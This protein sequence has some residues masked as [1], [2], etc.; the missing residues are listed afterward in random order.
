M[1][2]VV[3]LNGADGVGK[4]TQAQTIAETN[5]DL[6][7]CIS[8][9]GAY[10]PFSKITADDWWFDSS[11]PEEFCDV[12]YAS[13]KNRNLAIQNSNKPVVIVDKGL[14]NFEA[15][16]IA[17]LLTRGVSKEKVFELV[18]EYKRKYDIKSPEDVKI[19]LN[20][21]GNLQDKIEEMDRRGI[22]DGYSDESQKRYKHYQELQNI[23]LETQLE[24]GIYIPVNAS[25]SIEEVNNDIMGIV[26]TNLR[27]RIQPISNNRQYIGI[28]GL[29]ESG[30]ST[31]GRIF[32]DQSNIPNLK[33]KY[34]ARQIGTKYGVEPYSDIFKNDKR[35]LA[36]LMCDEIGIFLNDMYYWDVVSFESIHD[37]ELSKYMKEMQPFNYNVLYLD[38]DKN[39]R[40]GRNAKELDVNIN[41]SEKKVEMKD[42]DKISVGAD[43]VKEVADYVV[44]NNGR[45]EDLSKKLY[46]VAES[47]RRKVKMRH[48]AGGILVEDGKVLLVH[49][50]KEKDGIID[51]YY[52]VPGGGIE[53]GETLEDAT[54]RELKEE[55]G[56][57]VELTEPE[58]RYVLEGENGNQYFSLVEKVG[59][60]IGTGKGPE[61]TDPEYKNRGKYSAEMISIQDIVSGKINMVP[62]VIKEKFIADFAGK[63][64]NGMRDVDDKGDR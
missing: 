17:T 61:F 10:E 49:R 37:A 58:P 16:I 1:K 19:F 55:V 11:T 21:D 41:E 13:L 36:A 51:E 23:V 9:L 12:L 59:G 30:K 62:Q 7:E 5:P 40:I 39:L 45:L 2:L 35:I 32:L 48:R 56:I 24:N 18:K 25:K 33:F 38:T 63:K 26:S 42:E 53:E 6:V 64:R 27:H 57:D 8:G 50:I 52:V 43:T 4:T 60:I 46:N 3:S 44:N 22:N 15:R 29:S 54:K 28:G 20:L 34:I 14:D 31:S 47:V